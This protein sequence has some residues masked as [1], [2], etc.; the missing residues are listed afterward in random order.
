MVK[1]SYETEYN[2]GIGSNGLTSAKHDVL[3]KYYATKYP[4]SY[5]SA[6]LKDNIAFT[7]TKKVTDTIEIEGNSYP[8]ENYYYPQHEPF[9]PVLKEIFNL[10]RSKMIDG[11]IHCTG[12][13]QTKVLKF[14]EKVHI[15]KDNLFETPPIFQLIQSESGASWEEM[16][17]VFNMGNRMEFYVD[18]QI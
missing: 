12:G 5:D 1:A 3:S 14:S 18:E 17:R 16:Y 2:S 6:N 13:G 8:S 9:L 11:I 15:I 10:D 4:E 7:G